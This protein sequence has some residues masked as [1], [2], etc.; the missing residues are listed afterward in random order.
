MNREAFESAIKECGD[1]E[2]FAKNMQL[3]LACYAYFI[4][5]VNAAL[6]SQA[7]QE[8]AGWQRRLKF[9]TNGQVHQWE[10]CKTSEATD[11]FERSPHH[12]YRQIF[13]VQSQAQQPEKE[14]CTTCDGQISVHS[15][16]G[17]Y[18]G[19]CTICS[20]PQQYA[21]R[22]PWNTMDWAKHVGA[23]ET[24]RDTVEFGSW[25]AVQA[26]L[27]Q[28]Q[29]FTIGQMVQSQ[30]QQTEQEPYAYDV[31]TED[32]TE[33]AYAIY[34]TKYHNPLPEGAIPLYVIPPAPEGGQHEH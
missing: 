10:L 12:E 34:Y 27:I 7:Q 30:A 3:S 17:E 11:A 15:P 4:H 26:M 6:A 33:L 18:R 13:T 2:K 21:E 29:K 5:G 19:E 22:A 20:Q 9:S 25:M 32:G 1:E 14:P 28:F 24:E 23:W 16:D 8:P 31:P